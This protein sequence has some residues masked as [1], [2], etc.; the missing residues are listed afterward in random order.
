F[1]G[2]RRAGTAA[3]AP[4]GRVAAQGR[5]IAIGR[6]G[7]RRL[8]VAWPWDSAIDV[9]LEL[10]VQVQGQREVVGQAQL[11]HGAALVGADGFL[12][13]QKAAGY[14]GYGKS[15]RDL[16]QDFTFGIG[17]AGVRRIGDGGAQLARAGAEERPPADRG[18]AD[19]F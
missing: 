18:R 11:L 17:E 19:Q 15:L 10:L 4:A 13:A 9:L 2:G 12:A 7:S 14:L 16:A 5:G 6:R 1:R 3:P 8:D